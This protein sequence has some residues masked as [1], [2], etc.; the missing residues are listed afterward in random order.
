[1]KY[2]N[3]VLLILTA[4][5]LTPVHAQ[6]N[7]DPFVVV[8][9]PGHGGKDTGAL[10]KKGREK[11]INL[12]VGTLLGQYIAAKHP[13]VKII[14]TR[15]KDVFIGLKERAEI[16]NK[17][18]ANLFISIHTNAV[19]G[20]SAVNGA[21]V[22]TF[23]LSRTDENFEV[24]KR[25]NSVILLEDDY[26]Q[27]YEGFDPESSESY[28]MFEFIVTKYAEQSVNFASI[29]QKELV[30]TAK[31][32]DRGVKQAAY[33][34]L[35]ESS[36]PRILIELDF[37][38]NPSTE[39]F[40]LSKD[41]QNKLALAICNAFTQY[42]KD[43]D[44]GAGA[45]VLET[46]AEINTSAPDSV[47]EINTIEKGLSLE[48]TTDKS[49]KIYKVQILASTKEIPNNS[50]ELKGYKADFYIE[51]KLY[52]YTIGASSDRNEI[53]QLRRKVSKDFKNAF[54]IA[55]ENE[56]KIPNK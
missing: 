41:G 44:R 30:K 18:N 56:I 37:I 2:T 3:I 50:P 40:L 22:Y 9:D 16:A 39:N 25:E 33:L 20:H 27:K 49:S 13:D 10:G 54:I 43:F 28:I 5:L 35:R 55:F 17:S 11:D 42:K 48:D 6:V 12:A 32:N 45:P 46:V 52:K 23:G 7:K 8:I 15:K 34:V 4:V 21:E 26:A 53:N 47:A 51:N 19:S 29:V 14:H 36:M 1:M 24:A 31:R 38:S